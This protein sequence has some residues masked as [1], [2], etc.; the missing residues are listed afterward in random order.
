M[1]TMIIGRCPVLVGR[2]AELA[3][4]VQ[5]VE[6]ARQGGGGAVALVGEPG[7]GKSRLA[8]EALELGTVAGL[9]VACGRGSPTSKSPFRPFAEA[10]L[11]LTRQGSPPAAAGLAPYRPALARVVPEWAWTAAPVEPLPLVL[12][13]AVLRTLAA[14][15]KPHGALIVV[16]DLHWADPESLAVAEYVADNA[17]AARI[18]ILFTTRPESTSASL[19][20]RLADRNAVRRID[21]VPL[22]EREAAAM[23]AACLDPTRPSDDA[24]VASVVRASEGLPLVLEDLTALAQAGSPFDV[25]G[26][27]VESVSQRLAALGQQ[28]RE[29]LQAAA[30]F[31]HVVDWTLTAQ[32]CRLP[33]ARVVDALER[34]VTAQLLVREADGYAF[35]HALT[36]DAVLALMPPPARVASRRAAAEALE[37]VDDGGGQAIALAALWKGA[38]EPQRAARVL[39]GAGRAALQRAALLS[40]AG[41]LSEAVALDPGGPAGRA[42]R[43][44]L[45]TAHVRAGNAA[46]ALDAGAEVLAD[47][48][49]TL[50]RSAASELHLVL[51]RAACDAGRVEEGHDH[52][53]RA[54]EG[55][56]PRQRASA[57]ALQARLAMVAVTDDRL[58]SAEYLAQHAVA[59]AEEVGD[60]EVLCDALEVLGR[61]RRVRDL[62]SAAEAFDRAHAT[63]SAAGLELHAI[64]AL[65][66]LGTVDM[67]TTADPTR[68]LTARSAAER[69]GALSTVAAVDVN[70]AALF[71]MRGEYPTALRHAELVEQVGR[72]HRL[73]SL[74]A[75][76]LLFQGVVATHE[77]RYADMRRSVAAAEALAGDDPEILA[78]TW[79]MCRA[80]SSLLREERARALREFTRAAALLEG[81]PALAIDPHSGPWLLV[82]AVDGRV[83]TADVASFRGSVARGARWSRLWGGLAAAVVA[84]HIGDAVAAHQ[85]ATEA[86]E[87]GAP[88]PL[89]RAIGARLV[90]EAAIVGG[91]GDP[92]AWLG[93][94][95]NEFERRGHDRAAAACRDLLRRAGVPVP[96]PRDIDRAVRPDLRAR[97]VTAREAQVLD[98]LAD[99]LS[100][101]DIAQRLYLSPRTVEKHVGALLQKTGLGSRDALA[102][103]AGDPSYLA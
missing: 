72:R 26:R 35:R 94:A 3:A 52:L 4:L 5:L 70:L 93:P 1:P 46:A 44:D 90:A 47:H 69:A 97:G 85:E 60:A 39:A 50:D 20:Q 25:P 65:N 66:E 73:A 13:E 92:P 37:S 71:T 86:L 100:N 41:C 34:A 51:A 75:A 10:L 14:L 103:I 42:A 56:D 99:H 63:A 53:V 38:G 79:A 30:V 12:A 32:V 91:W 40:A 89:F 31:G 16:E 17:A 48:H 88:M 49:A 28:D 82:R 74:T 33:P 59:A 58:V 27:F 43:R 80:I 36:R 54:R 18:G 81:R 96:R 102:L 2:T 87:A 68:L 19:V 62:A 9:V 6:S 61:T 11:A 21:L 8:R 29:T 98:L 84:G 55:A 83:T 77:A 24:M 22:P 45:V 7:V 101:R 15:A 76:G 95:L 64:E 57:A 23:V 78:G 67:F